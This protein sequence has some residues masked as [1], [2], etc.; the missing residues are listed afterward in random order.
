MLLKE[1]EEEDDGLYWTPSNT[2]MFN[3]K[4]AYELVC[5]DSGIFQNTWWKDV[6]KLQ[7]PQRVK[8]FIWV[9]YHGKLMTN[10]ERCHRGM[11]TDPYCKSCH[12]KEEDFNHL[13][14]GCSKVREVW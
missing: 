14:R 9:L 3:V 2:G 4:S 7:V 6:W 1:S 8:T 10:K 11:S 13:F 5:S 12:G